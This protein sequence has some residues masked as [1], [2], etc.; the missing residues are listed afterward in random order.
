MI[1]ARVQYTLHILHIHIRLDETWPV[2]F[3]STII[4]P[5]VTYFKQVGYDKDSGAKR[6]MIDEKFY[7]PTEVEFLLGDPSKAKKAFG[8]EPTTKFEELV[9]EMVT[10]DIELMKKNSNA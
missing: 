10:A 3:C 2:T 7:R 5:G 6:I 9:A 4:I 1:H 8:W